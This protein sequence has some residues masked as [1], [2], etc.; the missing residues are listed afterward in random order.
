MPERLR[1]PAHR[2]LPLAPDDLASVKR[3]PEDLEDGGRRPAGSVV[4]RG[5]DALGV[6][7]LG[8]AREAE[9]GGAQLVD[10]PD[11]RRLVGVDLACDVVSPTVG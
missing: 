8:D 10:P 2:L 7:L 1:A 3:T 11:D 4:P 5:L 6:G 9:P